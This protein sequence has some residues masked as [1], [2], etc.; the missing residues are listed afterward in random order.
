MWSHYADD[1]KGICLRYDFPES[2]LDNEDEVLGVSQVS[3]E[4]NA[5]SNWLRSNIKLFK[6]DQKD[7]IINLLTTLLTSKA[8]SWSYEEEARIIRHVTGLFDVPRDML[9]HIIFGLQTSEAD[10]AL[11]RSIA[12]KY[13]GAIKFGRVVRTDED[14]G[15]NAEEI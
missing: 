1:H 7:F 10:E 5:I 8:P 4:P 3:Y 14:F 2:F 15:I 12:N 6:S 11:I 13:Y 9:T